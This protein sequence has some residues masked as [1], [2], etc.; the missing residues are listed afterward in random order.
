MAREAVL[1]YESGIL[2][3]GGFKNR[4]LREWP[5]TENGDL[6]ELAHTWKKGVLELKITKKKKKT[7]ILV[8]DHEKDDRFLAAQVE[9]VESLGDA[10]AK[11]GWLS[12]GTPVLSQYVSNPPTPHRHTHKPGGGWE[13]LR[14]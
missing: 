11:N 2:F 8:K 5:L 3:H 9:K 12:R 13:Y 14:V 1:N 10:K 4:G 6:S 7:Y